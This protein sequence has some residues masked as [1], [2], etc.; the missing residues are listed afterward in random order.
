MNFIVQNRNLSI[1]IAVSLA[2]HAG[3]LLVHFVGPENL[4]RAISPK[5]EVSLVN[6]NS[7]KKP[8]NP[9]KIAQADNEGG[10][11]SEQGTAA[12]PL[13]NMGRVENGDQLTLERKRVEELEAMQQKMLA[14]LKKQQFKTAPV[15]DNQTN[16]EAS[17]NGNE[18]RKS[19][20]ELALAA[21]EIA[22]RI[23]TENKRPK[24]TIVSPSTIR[25]SYARYYDRV[26]RHVEKVGTSNFPQK[27]GKK[28]YGELIMSI[29]IYHDGSLFTGDGNGGLVIEQS[30]GNP[31]LD[32]RAKA[33]VRSAATMSTDGFGVFP[34]KMR[35][36]ENGDI[37]VMITTFRFTHEDELEIDLQ[38][39]AK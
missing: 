20:R 31:A 19:S 5:L 28:L 6:F 7:G 3:I 37:L 14:D 13:P 17:E 29:Y 24:R 26:K 15:V 2:L 10:G 22:K 36:S 33:I 4:R 39:E 8:L 16:P 35:T 23:E 34:A 30:S 25:A 1:A 12:S 18:D 21:A 32:E 27:N 9:D 11:E 38:G